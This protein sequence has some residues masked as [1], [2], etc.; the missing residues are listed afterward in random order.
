MGSETPAQPYPAL[1]SP[2]AGATTAVLTPQTPTSPYPDPRSPMAS[3]TTA[4]ASPQKPTSPYPGLRSFHEHESTI[5]FGRDDQIDQLVE[6]LESN[7]LVAVTGDSGCGKSS[8]VRAGLL[9]ALHAGQ[10]NG[11]RTQW[12]IAEFRPGNRPIC[13]LAE[14]LA[15]VLTPGPIADARLLAA[16][17][18]YGPRSIADIL[19]DFTLAPDTEILIVVDQF[20]ELIRF[21]ERIDRDEAD[22]FVALLLETVAD[23]SLP[24]R[25]VLTLRTDYLG[26]CA[27]FAGLPEVLNGSQYLVPRLERRQLHDAIV[28]PAREFNGAVESTL[29][30]QLINEIGRHQDQLP[31]LEHALL[32]M[33]R[34]ARERSGAMTQPGVPGPSVTLTINDYIALGGIGEAL[35]RHATDVYEK[36]DDEAKKRIARRMF[37]ALWDEGVNGN[38]TRRPCTVRDAAAIAGVDVAKLKHVADAFRRTEHSFLMPPPD[39]ELTDDSVLD[40]SHE[41][42]FRHWE[43]LKQWIGKEADNAKQYRVW[44]TEANQR[45]RHDGDLLS[46][47]AIERALAWYA[48]VQPTAAWARRYDEHPDDFANLERFLAESRRARRARAWINGVG[49]AL[50]SICLIVGLFWLASYHEQREQDKQRVELLRQQTYSAAAFG[51]RLEPVRALQL[52]LEAQGDSDNPQAGT[53]LRA[54]LRVSHLR[55][56]VFPSLGVFGDA[57]FLD[58]SRIVTV[59]EGDGLAVWDVQTGRRLAAVYDA[60]PHRLAVH[61]G[62]VAALAAT[63]SDDGTIDL[64]DLS[65]AKHPKRVWMRRLQVLAI[66]DI[67][68]SPD[69]SL[70]ATASEDGTAVLWDTEHGT[71]LAPLV[72]HLGA[73]VAIAFSHDSRRLA[74]AG[75]DGRIVLWEAGSGKKVGPFARMPGVKRMAFDA[76]GRYLAAVTCDG[77][78]LWDPIT[79]R[80]EGLLLN[81]SQVMAIAF[82]SDG[83]RIAATGL[84]GMLRVSDVATRRQLFS[85]SADVPLHDDGRP[86]NEIVRSHDD[87]ASWLVTVAFSAS[88]RQLVTTGRDGSAKIWDVEAGGELLTFRAHERAIR[89]IA[90]SPD[91]QRIATASDDGT[92]AVWS[93]DGTRLEQIPQ[94]AASADPVPALAFDMH[95]TRLAMATGKR[96]LL[97]SLAD[98]ATGTALNLDTEVLDVQA[99]HAHERFA[100]AAGRS[101]AIW[102]GSTTRPDR[103]IDTGTTTHAV[104]VS[105]DDQIVAGECRDGPA[106]AEPEYPRQICLWDA[107]SGARRVVL[108]G[109]VTPATDPAYARAGRGEA[110]RRPISALQFSPDGAWLASSSDDKM[111]KI[112]NID[113]QH[114]VGTL[115]ATL[116]GHRESIAGL[117]IS[118]NG[119]LLVTAGNDLV[120]MW[121]ENS[122]VTQD[123]FPD[124]EHGSD[125]VAFSPAGT[126][127]AAGGRDG[128]VRVYA[129]ESDALRPLARQRTP[130]H[131]T[132]DECRRYASQSCREPRT[133]LQIANEGRHLLQSGPSFYGDRYL[134]IAAQQDPAIFE[135]ER[136]RFA[137]AQV[138]HR[139]IDATA[140][141]LTSAAQAAAKQTSNA[142][143][144][145]E[146]LAGQLATARTEGLGTGE[147]ILRQVHRFDNS[148]VV[149]R[150]TLPSRVAALQLAQQAA[151]FASSRPSWAEQTFLLT[152]H[153]IKDTTWAAHAALTAR[154]YAMI[155]SVQVHLDR[156]EQEAAVESIQIDDLKAEDRR[157]H[158]LVLIRIIVAACDAAEMPDVVRKLGSQL[159]HDIDDVEVL[160]D[161]AAFFLRTKQPQLAITVLH[162]ALELD[163]TNDLALAQ[164]GEAQSDTGQLRDALN[165]FRKV[166]PMAPVYPMAASS[167]GQIAYDNLQRLSDGY[168]WMGDAIVPGDPQSW[169]NLAEAAWG[170]KRFPEAR[171]IA[172]RVIEA[173]AVDPPSLE[174]EVA[175]RFVLVATLY[176]TQDYRAAETEL[177][178]LIRLAPRFDA[179]VQAR[180]SDSIWKYR[181]DRAAVSRVQPPAARR[182]LDLLLTYCES[183]GKTGDPRELHKLLHEARDAHAT[184]AR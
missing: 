44:L 4:V 129:V 82:N 26:G 75:T 176:Q 183:F 85:T 139:A 164:L 70:L 126:A 137:E 5:F 11:V 166:S 17:L 92:A 121:N 37:C 73:V 99:F 177:D 94:A 76:T 25:V 155:E 182:F 84:D 24:V 124:A 105:P 83:R 181:G 102:G 68:F 55:S 150:T 146:R 113:G 8:L 123:G 178:G 34:Q 173:R 179:T 45:V 3:A 117:A 167:A 116:R 127:F 118:P 147:Q 107:D 144:G 52:A 111:V 122:Y 154:E 10:L 62:P 43:L 143:D 142:E 78:R 125:S 110:H 95:G 130:I 156:G 53:A 22:A 67:A 100:V 88:G 1:R 163:E 60:V 15:G 74:T 7:R 80:D 77:V 29:A 172:S 169:A 89:S 63:A 9:P 46:N 120:R 81:A 48:D 66:T 30:N 38:G 33:W 39:C 27:N 140:A 145:S 12:R 135:L 59:G 175:M 91:G 136:W 69:G 58:D 148:I 112:W 165:T 31:V 47:K 138:I 103:T 19:K 20:E 71:A 28:K 16:R 72:D 149:D 50:V 54:A 141:P 114:H 171:S 106:D 174:V 158:Q 86:A 115:L 14:K 65:D 90:Y 184:P 13:N 151:K 132:D 56:M 21:R 96:V 18:R 109:P 49:A 35:S 168:R 42:L 134:A 36:L 104:A 6:R 133:P 108:G 160:T 170:N 79:R 131:L 153:D 61:T 64:W 161:F 128:V 32:A 159:Y 97:W 23:P 152:P 162:R 41:S 57:R 51:A 40:I 2:M 157:D 93:L 98:H 119:K 180:S 101:L 87:E